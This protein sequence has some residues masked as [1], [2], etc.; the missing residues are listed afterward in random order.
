MNSKEFV[1]LMNMRSSFNY[2]F[3]SDTATLCLSEIRYFI[4]STPTYIH[5]YLV[6]K[7]LSSF[8]HIII[9]SCCIHDILGHLNWWR[10]WHILTYDFIKVIFLKERNNCLFTDFY[11]LSGTYYIFNGTF[12]IQ[13]KVIRKKKMKSWKI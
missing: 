1:L 3:F 12:H 11:W 8:L 13:K 4:E 9:V 2:I 10:K 5:H 7:M 6:P